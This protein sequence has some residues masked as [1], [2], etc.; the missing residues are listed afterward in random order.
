MLNS[1]GLN[2]ATCEF[3]VFTWVN[4]ETSGLV[5][6]CVIHFC[7]SFVIVV[8]LG[9]LWNKQELSTAAIKPSDILTVDL[10]ESPCCAL[11]PP[12]LRELRGTLPQESILEIYTLGEKYIFAPH[13]SLRG[14]FLACILRPRIDSCVRALYCPLW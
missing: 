8:F 10:K 11:G 2:L 6:H 7:N 5:I 4:F 3:L 1:A 12:C 13:Q 9:Q 14:W